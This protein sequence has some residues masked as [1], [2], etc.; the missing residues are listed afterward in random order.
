MMRRLPSALKSPMV[1]PYTLNFLGITKNGG[2]GNTDDRC[3]NL[4]VYDEA[5][6]SSV[7]ISITEYAAG[8]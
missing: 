7:S 6:E 8:D 1:P 5:T 3:A 4:I 2:G